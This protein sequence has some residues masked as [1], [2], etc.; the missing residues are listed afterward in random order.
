M[1]AHVLF[2]TNAN[3]ALATFAF[4][5]EGWIFYSAVN[6]AVP[7]IVLNL[8][9]EHDSWAISVR[10]LS[11]QLTI[12]LFP[13]IISGCATHFKDLRSPLLVTFVIF[14]A[15]CIFYATILPSWNAAQIGIN[16]VAG[17]GQVG[18]LTLLPACIQYTAPH[19]F[20][21]TATGNAFSAGAVGGALGSAVPDA[22]INGWLSTHYAAAV[23][24]A[25]ENAGLPSTSGDALLGALAAGITGAAANVTDATD[26]V[27]T[28]HLPSPKSSSLMPTGSHG[29]VSFL[30]WSL[31]WSPSGS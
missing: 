30:L 21:S 28:L 15:V 17:I 25:A 13:L 9:F 23:L 4:A 3:F 7:Q 31:R 11:F 24:S 8:G 6:S 5:V 1:V 14:L 12:F 22:I 20:L 16:V 18:P 26:A 29:Q 27:W 10:Q 19:A 2:S